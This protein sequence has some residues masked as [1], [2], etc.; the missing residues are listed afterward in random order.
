VVTT[1]TASAG[2]LQSAAAALGVITSFVASAATAGSITYRPFTG[3]TARPGTGRT[4]R[5]FTSVTPR[6]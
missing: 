2:G 3:A 5:P 6:P 4:I 1:L